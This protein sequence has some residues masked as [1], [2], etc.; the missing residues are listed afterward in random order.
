MPTM[1]SDKS[2][3]SGLTTLF[4]RHVHFLELVQSLVGGNVHHIRQNR[5]PK[6]SL[7]FNLHV[8][9][10]ACEGVGINEALCCCPGVSGGTPY[11][12]KQVKN[13]KARLS[14]LSQG[15]LAVILPPLFLSLLSFCT[16]QISKGTTSFFWQGE[17]GQSRAE[18]SVRNPKTGG[19]CFCFHLQ[20]VHH[21][22][23]LEYL[24]NLHP[25]YPVIILCQP[26]CR[27]LSSSPF[28]FSWGNTLV[29]WEG[30]KMQQY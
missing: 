4:L 11:C 14:L 21:A 27:F 6:L 26:V 25:P 16:L 30:S 28:P 9:I 23:T 19:A 12:P 5:K 8:G 7:Y 13:P 15:L 2:A 3:R 17:A 10:Q 24:Q 22:H 20:T 29:K 18:S 1:A